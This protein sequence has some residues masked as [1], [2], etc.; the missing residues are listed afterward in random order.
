[1][2]RKKIENILTKSAPEPFRKNKEAVIDALKQLNISCNT[3]IAELYLKYQAPFEEREDEPEILEIT[4]MIRPNIIDMTEHFRKH[5]N[6]PKY[7]VALTDDYW[8]KVWFYH[9]EN[10]CVHEISSENLEDIPENNLPQWRD[11]NAFL[12]WYFEIE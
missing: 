3:L 7:F 10:E 4:K 1:M 2:I 12:E 5:Y 6:I 9:I 11:F 8:G